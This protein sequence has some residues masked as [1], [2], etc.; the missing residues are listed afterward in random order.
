[1]RFGLLLEHHAS[2]EVYCLLGVFL[3]N[4]TQLETLESDVG[5]VLASG[6][7]QVSTQRQDEERRNDDA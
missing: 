2:G 5:L 3:E 4:S 7:G 6:H 1:M